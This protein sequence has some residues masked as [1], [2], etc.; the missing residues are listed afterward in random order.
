MNIIRSFN[1]ISL[2]QT[3]YLLEI[4]ERFGMTDCK[5]ISI[6]MKSDISNVIM[7]FDDNYKADS[8]IIY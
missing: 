2:N 8:D 1:R 3:F 4:L 6:L 5:S 7:S